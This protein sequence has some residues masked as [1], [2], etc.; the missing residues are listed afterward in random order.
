MLAASSRWGGDGKTPAMRL[1]LAERPMS[2]REMLWPEG[3]VRKP[4]RARRKGRAV[5]MPDKA[6]RRA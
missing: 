3:E 2:Y 5:A 6:A 4:R 1:G